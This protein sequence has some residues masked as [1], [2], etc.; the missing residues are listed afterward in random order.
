MKG[1]KLAVLSILSLILL[2]GC[3]I[4]PYFTSSW[5]D[6]SSGNS[7]YNP[8]S[9]SAISNTGEGYYKPSSFNPDFAAL[10]EETG[11][12]NLPSTGA[13][14]ILVIPVQFPDAGCS[15]LTRGCA[16]TKSDIQKTF[17]GSA[18]DTGWESVASYYSASSYGK[19]TLTGKVTDWFT[20]DKTTSQ[21]MAVTNLGDPTYYVLRAAVSWYKANNSDI[22]D[23]DQNHDG[24]IDAVWLVY[25]APDYSKASSPSET[26]KSL[27]WAYTYWDYNQNG[28]VL[29]PVGNVYGWG[30]YDFMYEGN[31]GSLFEKKADAHTYIHE[32]GHMM[33]LDDYYSYT[34]GDW[35][36][37][38]GV[39]MMDY[40]IADH[41]AYSKMALDWTYPYVIDGTAAS[42]TIALNP[43]ES[44]GDC[45]LIN[46]SWNGS[47]M[48]E[49]LLIEFYTPTGLNYLDSRSGGYP[50][51]GLQAFSIPGIKIYHIDAR[52]GHFDWT[53]SSYLNALTDTIDI[54]SGNYYTD[55]AVSNSSEY[56]YDNSKYKMVHLLEAGKT[57]TFKTG[58]VAT[59]DTLFTG[60]NTFTPSSFSSFFVNPGK[61]DDGS[62]IGYSISVE[63]VS[64]SSASVSITRI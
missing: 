34:D 43:F 17:F 11:Y 55:F 46:D 42:T 38:G 16:T 6:T 23:F 39:D 40:N 28:S 47:Q 37:A 26:Y 58:S 62:A 18:S 5:G 48:D 1:K 10:R 21:L 49:Y 35:G 3:D 13:Q 19:L 45:I 29:S 7:V 30:S 31:Y 52:M 57:N 44:S 56:S 22:T 25:S 33:G 8:S 12:V 15:S 20:L 14:K 32:T 50:G 36:A 64:N 59:N 27:Y 9:N 61:F 2:T 63:S 41:D 51:N 24:Y 54:S 4:I 53:T 60:G